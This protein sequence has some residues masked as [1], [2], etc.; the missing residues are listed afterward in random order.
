MLPSM[1]ITRS[2]LVVI[3]LEGGGGS[4]PK[5]DSNIY[6]FDDIS[7]RYGRDRKESDC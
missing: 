4:C 2:F 3:C 6:K 5:S 7:I 1:T